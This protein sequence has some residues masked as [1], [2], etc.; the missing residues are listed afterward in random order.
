MRRKQNLA[1]SLYPKIKLGVTMNF[2][3]VT[4][5]QFGKNCH[6]LLC[7]LLSFII[8]VASVNSKKCLV[9]PN[10]LFGFQ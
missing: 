1:C 6:A 9:T 4:K 3:E 5:L 8:I 2:F 7:I 10:F